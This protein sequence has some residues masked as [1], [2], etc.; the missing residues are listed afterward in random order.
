MKI[1]NGWVSNSSSS[2]FVGIGWR[3]THY[4]NEITK[5]V[6]ELLKSLNVEI[7]PYCVR[8]DDYHYFAEMI[9]N[10]KE[11]K[12]NESIFEPL[13]MYEEYDGYILAVPLS[14][15][16]FYKFK[17]DSEAGFAGSLKK[18]ID[19]Q[20]LSAIDSL[21]KVLGSPKLIITEVSC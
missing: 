1:R 17:Y 8:D 11:V 19:T 21:A 3:L 13:E 4:L 2:S 6:V 9:R 12:G 18:C 5:D 7:S 16:V 14:D 15:G 20:N 10:D